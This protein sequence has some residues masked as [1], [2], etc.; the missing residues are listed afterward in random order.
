MKTWKNVVKY[1]NYLGVCGCMGKSMRGMRE[2]SH[3]RKSMRI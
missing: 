2:S 3:D 1:N